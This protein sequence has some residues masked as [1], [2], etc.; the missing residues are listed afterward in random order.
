MAGVRADSFDADERLEHSKR[1]LQAYK[2]TSYKLQATSYK[3]APTGS[4]LLF[5]LSGKRMEVIAAKAA[6]LLVTKIFTK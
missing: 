3:Q 1:Q 4:G 5:L 6:S 2:P